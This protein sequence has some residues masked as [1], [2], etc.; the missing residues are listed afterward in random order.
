[1]VAQKDL[2]VDLTL[3]PST[4]KL[5]DEIMGKKTVDPAEERKRVGKEEIDF[6]DASLKELQDR[7][8]QQIAAINKKQQEK[9][10]AT[11]NIFLEEVSAA[12]AESRGDLGIGLAQ[13]AANAAKRMGEEEREDELALIDALRDRDWETSSRNIFIVA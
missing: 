6:I 5:L 2:D 3:K 4:Q 13:G 8:S 9:D 1:M 12:L 10:Y 7:K 11:M